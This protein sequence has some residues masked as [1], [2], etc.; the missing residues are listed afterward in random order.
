MIKKIVFVCGVA[1]GL[2]ANAQSSNF[3]GA[4]VALN[5]N[6][7]TL[8][9]EVASAISLGETSTNGSVQGAYSFALSEKGLFSVGATYAMGDLK[10]GSV[11]SSSFTIKAQNL[12]TVYVEP[13]Y[14]IGTT[15]IY[16][17]LAYIGTKVASTGS[18]TSITENFTGTGY[19][20]GVRTMLDKNIFMQVEFMNAKFNSK[21]ID[22]ES[23]EPGGTVGTVGI[24]YKF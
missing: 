24:G 14:V 18:T 16:G 12:Y 4:S 23:V 1:C 7:A 8:T 3:E 11:S 15:A 5:V 9:T 17:K 13:A 10:A 6:S 2:S 20:F 22:S 19:G 21:T